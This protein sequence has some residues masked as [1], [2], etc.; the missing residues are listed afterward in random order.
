M[1]A[2]VGGGPGLTVTQEQERDKDQGY[3]TTLPLKMED[4][5]APAMVKMWNHV[6]VIFL[7]C[8]FL[9]SRKAVQQIFLY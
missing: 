6:Q 9:V 8:L 2:G 1:V 5:G 3:A 7:E 4:I